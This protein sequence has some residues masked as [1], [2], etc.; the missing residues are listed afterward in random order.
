MKNTGYSGVG[1]PLSTWYASPPS[2]TV[3]GQGKRLWGNIS[4]EL[5]L[6]TRIMVTGK[7]PSFLFP[8]L[9]EAF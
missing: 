1:K 2:E 7:L 4:P 8:I 3:C 6:C 9:L 5:G